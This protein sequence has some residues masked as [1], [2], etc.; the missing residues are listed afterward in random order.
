[1]SKKEQHEQTE[2]PTAPAIPAGAKYLIEVEDKKA[3]LKAINRATLEVVLGL[4]MPSN[5]DPQYI[6]AGEIILN[7]C[8]VGGDEEIRTDEEY[9]NAAAM[10]AYQLVE[11]KTASLKKL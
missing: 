1:M 5:G 3:Y 10:Q 7:T 9:L 11:I 4:I 6:K 2:I 8:W